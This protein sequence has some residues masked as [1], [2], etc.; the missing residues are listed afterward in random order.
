MLKLRSF[1]FQPCASA[2][3][4]VTGG[5]SSR[6]ESRWGAEISCTGPTDTLSDGWG[7]TKA[8][9]P[10]L[11]AAGCL[12][13]CLAGLARLR[14]PAGRPDPGARR[15]LPRPTRL[16]SPTSSATTSPG[17][18]PDSTKR[19]RVRVRCSSRPSYRVLS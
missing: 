3:S 10:F 17:F 8:A 16:K 4:L 12:G 7:S 14:S 15:R 13:G 5:E 2:S 19:P 18:Q 9:R 6:M 1:S 11:P